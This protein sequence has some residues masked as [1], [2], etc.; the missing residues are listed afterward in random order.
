[1]E[2]ISIVGFLSAFGVMAEGGQQHLEWVVAVLPI[3]PSPEV[4]DEP[5]AKPLLV[6][7]AL[8]AVAP[9]IADGPVVRLQLIPKLS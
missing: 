6:L 9:R 2:L 3:L 7:L 4:I 5:G 1:M 8:F